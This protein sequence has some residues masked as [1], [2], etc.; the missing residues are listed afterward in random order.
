MKNNDAFDYFYQE[1]SDQ[2]SFYRIPKSL[3]IEDRFRGIST[4]AKVLY[5]LLLDR[6]SLSTKN[7]WIDEQGRIY[8]IYT[9]R[10]IQLSL[11][12]GDKKAT[13]LLAELETYGLIEKRKRGQGKPTI[14]YVK[15][16]I[17]SSKQRFKDCQSNDSRV[18][19][20]MIL[21]QLK[22]RCNYTDRI[23]TD[24]SNTNH[25]L[26]DVG[27]K[28]RN[29]YRNY[30]KEE[31]YI[32]T[33]KSDYPYNEEIIEGILELILDVVCSKKETVRIAGEDMPINIVKSRFMKLNFSHIVYVINCM[34]E[35]TTKVRSIKQYLLTALYN[36][37][38]TIGSYYQALVNNDMASGK[39]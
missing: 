9:I 39:V 6:V 25:I 10:N 3:F 27:M 38:I 8:I 22:Q 34:K 5:G 24:Y 13:S 29:Q 18:V 15:N 30:L 28:E 36:A 11:G 35:N 16:F 33:I 20:T 26:S 1:Q 17:V 12:C 31:L 7:K 21:D 2:F 4:D 37:P 19:E 23:K 14:I 32:E